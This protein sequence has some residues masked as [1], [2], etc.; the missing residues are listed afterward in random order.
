LDLN[1]LLLNAWKGKV[2]RIISIKSHHFWILQWSYCGY[3]M[4]VVFW[5]EKTK[6]SWNR[7]SWVRHLRWW[8]RWMRN[9]K[10]PVVDGYVC[11]PHRA[12]MSP[13][14]LERLVFLKC[15]ID[16]I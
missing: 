5:M 10:S 1:M 6:T 15:N 12:Q 3:T 11:I 13:S 4:I 16:L 9:K 2:S 7:E 14:T 8:K